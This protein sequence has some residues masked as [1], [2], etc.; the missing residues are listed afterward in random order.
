MSAVFLTNENKNGI[1]LDNKFNLKEYRKVFD[2]MNELSIETL[3]E[4]S[5]NC[6]KFAIENLLYETFKKK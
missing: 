4:M 2:E 3:K 5:E 6:Y 1:L